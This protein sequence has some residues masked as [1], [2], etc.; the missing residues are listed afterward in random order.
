MTDLDLAAVRA[1]LTVLDEGQFGYAADVLGITQ[2][3]VSKRIVKL[4]NQLGVVVVER[5]P[6]GVVATAAGRRF[7]PYARS[8]LTVA[9]EAV[10]AVRG[11]PL[12]VALLGERDAAADLM[13]YYLDRHPG[14]EVE[15]VLS[16]VRD[17]SRDALVAGRVDAAFARRFGGPRSLPDEICCAPAYL[18]PLQLLV[19]KG[20][21]LAGRVE[22]SLA[23]ASAYPAWVPG[24]AVPSE[25][26]D[27]YRE[28][29]EFAGI[30]VETGG[31]PESIDAV[32]ERVAASR[33]LT[34]F[35]GTGFRT[36]L[37]PGIRGVRVV[38]PTPAYPHA[39]LWWGVDAHPGLAGLVAHVRAGYNADVAA[40]CWVPEADR[41]LFGAEGYPVATV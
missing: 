23:E 32:L 18:E 22:V 10:G 7:L 14:V 33:A 21:P 37:H 41:D 11:R 19:G 13:R 29:S 16:S 35:T 17:T 12:R 6:R 24:A 39:L 2:Q 27:F 28:L 26:A 9:D 5:G 30:T 31:Q 38:D 8:L 34:T 36:P 1:F 20:H 40:G 25:W 15:I 3:A 4:E